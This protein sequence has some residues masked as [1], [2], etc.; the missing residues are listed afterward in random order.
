[1]EN[2]LAV[3][4][5]FR[6]IQGETSYTGLPCTFVRLAGCN[7][8]CEYCDTHYA[9]TEEG[10]Q[11][12][13]QE[14]LRRVRRAG[15]RLVCVT[16]GEPLLQAEPVA[17]LCEELLAEGH[18]VLLE[19]NGTRS[20]APVP[21]GVV[22]IMDVK[23]PGSGEADQTLAQNW[24]HIGEHDEVKFVVSD[25]TDFDWA[26]AFIEQHQL[27]GGGPEILFSPVQERVRPRQL[28]EWILESRLDVRL[29][30]QLHRLLWPEKERGI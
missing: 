11:M 13:V 18:T 26:A 9:R 28:A 1:M 16:G 19:T 30:V 22:V 6:S 21:P 29:Q 15:G 20:L 27:L 7:L 3:I 10:R 14:V 2:Q 4:E 5:V 25:R 12:S 8:A 23:C 24:Q 17:R